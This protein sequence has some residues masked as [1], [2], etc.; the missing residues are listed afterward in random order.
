MITPLFQYTRKGLEFHQAAFKLQ[1]LAQY[2]WLTR[3]A[4]FM[5]E[6]KPLWQKEI[7]VIMNGR[8]KTTGMLP[9]EKY[10]GDIDDKVYSL[11]SNSNCWHAMRE[12]GVILNELGDKDQSERMMSTAAEYRKIILAAVEKAKVRTTDPP[13]LPVAVS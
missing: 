5:R 4:E 8:E 7:D 13:F 11:N 12:M 10:C 9:R 1:M 3:D 2:Y 6:I